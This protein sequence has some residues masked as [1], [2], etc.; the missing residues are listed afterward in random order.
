MKPWYKKVWPWVVIGVVI[1]IFI[2]VL[3]FLGEVNRLAGEISEGTVSHETFAGQIT[4]SDIGRDIGRGLPLSVVSNDDP[5]FGPVAAQVVVVEFGDFEC[6]YCRQV[7]PTVRQLMSEYKNEVKFIF[8]DFP[9]SSV[10]PSAQ[11][12]AEAAACAHEQGLFWAYH[13]KLFINQQ[14]LS[15]TALL[16]YAGQV[17]LETGRFVNCLSSG[18]YR[19]EVID[20]LQAG[21]N[22]GVEGTPTFFINGIRYEGSLSLEIFRQ[23][24]DHA[25]S[26]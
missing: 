18:T 2:L 22:A 4:K 16:A 25:L 17:G 13:D 19:A 12:A 7:F 20:D 10:H 14:D 3:V 21:V 9:I 1:I 8:R 15:E 26:I 11:L 5:Y 6:P 24:I 23:L